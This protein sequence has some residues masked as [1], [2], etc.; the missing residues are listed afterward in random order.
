MNGYLEEQNKEISEA[1]SEEMKNLE[2][3]SS[4]D[5]K[6]SEEIKSLALIAHDNKK[7]SLLEW[8]KKNKGT[9]K[10][11]NLY[12]TGTTGTRIIE[13]VGLKV[14]CLR[15][16]PHGG[17]MQIGALIADHKLSYLIFFWDPMEAHPHDV[18]VKALLR[19]AVLYDVPIACNRSTANYIITSKLFEN[20]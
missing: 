12:A 7:E 15:S 10:N 20:K 18:D 4:R 9:L 16:G 3:E 17:D 5:E 2:E 14:H 19:V 1:L 8:V 6:N 11:Y 13:E